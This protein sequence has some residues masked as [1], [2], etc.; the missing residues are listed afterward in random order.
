MRKKVGYRLCIDREKEM[1]H[2]LE[3][4]CD[5]SISGV[6]IIPKRVLYPVP[7]LKLLEHQPQSI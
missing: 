6:L 4:S 3:Q 1:A 5:I 2:L 7:F